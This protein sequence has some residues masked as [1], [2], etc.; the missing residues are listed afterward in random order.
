VGPRPCKSSY[1]A[2][3][4]IFIAKVPTPH[5]LHLG[6]LATITM[7]PIAVTP[8]AV[9][10]KAQPTFPTSQAASVDPSNIGTKRKIICFSGTVP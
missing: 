4:P 7:A 6:I 8:P 3:W 9:E 1:K 2:L 10:A 5:A